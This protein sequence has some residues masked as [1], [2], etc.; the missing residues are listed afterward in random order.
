MSKTFYTEDGKSIQ[1]QR[2]DKKTNFIN[3]VGSSDQ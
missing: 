1:I 3:Y 2:I